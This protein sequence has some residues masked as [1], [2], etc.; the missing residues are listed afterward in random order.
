MGWFVVGGLVLEVGWLAGWV[1]V[2]GSIGSWLVRGL[3]G[4]RLV[5]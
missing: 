5:G 2:G 1:R 3:L 4:G